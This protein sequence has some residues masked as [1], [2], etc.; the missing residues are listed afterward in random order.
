MH[1]AASPRRRS[2][3]GGTLLSP[4]RL[5]TSRL[6]YVAEEKLL[7][8]EDS[9]LR[10]CQPSRVFDDACDVGYTVVS[11]HTGKEVVYVQDEIVKRDGEVIAWRYS[12]AEEGYESLPVLEIF[13]D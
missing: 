2:R 7:C 6:T 3:L 12:P 9:D 8:T 13:N 11:H 4:T 1:T 5:C 10:N